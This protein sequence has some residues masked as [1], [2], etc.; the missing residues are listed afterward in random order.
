MRYAYAIFVHSWLQFECKLISAWDRLR[1]EEKSI[2][3]THTHSHERIWAT[4]VVAERHT[5]SSFRTT[6]ANAA[7]SCA[8]NAKIWRKTQLNCVHT[9]TNPYI[10]RIKRERERRGKNQFRRLSCRKWCVWEQNMQKIR[11]KNN[12]KNCAKRMDIRKLH[13]TRK[14]RLPNCRQFINFVFF[15]SASFCCSILILVWCWFAFFPCASSTF[16]PYS[17]FSKVPWIH[18]EKR[19]YVIF[20]S[21]VSHCFLFFLS[22]PFFCCWLIAL[23]SF[24]SPDVLAFHYFCTASA[25]FIFAQHTPTTTS[26]II[27]IY[28]YLYMKLLCYVCCELRAA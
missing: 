2:K 10:I 25:D 13:I 21:T 15:F 12:K 24:F 14:S 23:I 28:M 7:E 5:T 1:A 16:M 9:Q 18:S 11:K 22:F 19:I 17:L 26:H 4:A 3:R 20:F 27:F 6:K 8:K